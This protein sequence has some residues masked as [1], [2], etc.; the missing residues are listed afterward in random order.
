MNRLR[1]LVL[2]S[3]VALVGLLAL[4][5]SVAGAHGG[6][7]LGLH[8][9]SATALVREAAERLNVTAARLTEAIENAAVAR[10]DEAVREDDIDADDAVELKEAARDNVGFAMRVSR[11]RTVATN[12][13][14]TTERLN[15]AFRAARRALIVERIDEAV[16]DGDLEADEAAELKQDLEDADLPGYKAGFGRGFGLGFG[17]L[18]F[19]R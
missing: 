5:P 14:I 16:E 15:D 13:G 6:R 2:V 18:G 8:G 17:R 12:L 4:G 1:M 9:T 11:T 10:I 19:R 7:G 3:A